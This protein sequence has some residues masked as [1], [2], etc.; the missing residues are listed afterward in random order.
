MVSL[1]VIH[2]FYAPAFRIKMDTVPGM[3][4]YAWFLPEQEGEY[5]VL[6]AEYCGLKH[7]DMLATIHVLSVEDYTAWLAG[8]KDV[9]VSATT[10][11]EEYGCSGCHSLDGSAGVGPTLYDMHGKP[12][13]V[14]TREGAVQ[15]VMRDKAYLHRALVD[16]NAEIVEGYDP[17]MPTAE[18]LLSDEELDR[19]VD[20]FAGREAE[21]GT[22]E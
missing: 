4:T 20:F 21:K 1:D 7:A 5:D 19:L 6:C 14:T 8:E 3:Q 11:L 12:V 9:T 10:L 18:G 13:T 15:E 16:P 17:I 22:G 2:S